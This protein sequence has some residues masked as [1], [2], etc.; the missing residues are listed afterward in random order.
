MIAEPPVA[1]DA[2]RL[3]TPPGSDA[4]PVVAEPATPGTRRSSRAS[5]HV[6][7]AVGVGVDVTAARFTVRGSNLAPGSTVVITTNS[8][9]VGLGTA[10]ADPS[11]SVQWDGVL[12]S[13]LAD[14]EHTLVAEAVA[15]DGS[16][17]ERIAPFGVA[18]GV[19]VR[20]G[21]STITTDTTAV[22]APATT[23]ADTLVAEVVAVSDGGGSSLPKLLLVVLA[24]GGGRRRRRAVALEGRSRRRSRRSGHGSARSCSNQSDATN[25]R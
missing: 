9:S 5:V 13:D 10:V 17:V 11:G 16:A 7:F 21:E 24:G 15:A 12:P 3:S 22:S 23:T 2:A 6:V 14:G 4:P 20:I 19:L 25:P 1:T 18:G 8:D